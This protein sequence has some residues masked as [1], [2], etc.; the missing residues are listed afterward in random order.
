[1]ATDMSRHMGDIN[2][3]K[4]ICEEISAGDGQLLPDQINAEEK[5][6]RKKK[7]LELVVHASDISF[8]ARPRE[9]RLTQAYLLFE[10]FFRQGDDELERGLPVSFLCDR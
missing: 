6:K 9:A 3:L 2:E 10:E 8:L 7:V 5:E 4:A 1:M